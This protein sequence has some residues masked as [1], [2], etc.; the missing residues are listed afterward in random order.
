LQSGRRTGTMKVILCCLFKR[1][2]DYVGRRD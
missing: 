2:V 1:Q